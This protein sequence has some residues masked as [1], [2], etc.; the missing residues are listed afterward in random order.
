[1]L[2]RCSS[3]L[4]SEDEASANTC[5]INYSSSGSTG[6][7]STGRPRMKEPPSN[8]VA[9]SLSSWLVQDRQEL[10]VKEAIHIR[11]NHPSLNR[12]GSL[13]LPECWMAALKSTSS[14]TDQRPVAPTDS[15]SDSSWWD[16]RLYTTSV[17]HSTL[18]FRFIFMLKKAR[19][20][21]QCVGKTNLF[22]I[23]ELENATPFLMT[24]SA[25]KPS[26]CI[27]VH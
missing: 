12:D 9:G 15:S 21:D 4:Q 25:E 26:L 11:L 3:L 7:V 5:H 22:Q 23:L 14:G 20:P 13:E 8:Q 16:A 10:L 6:K 19:A 24:V 1:M 17:S 2:V 18:V 27:H